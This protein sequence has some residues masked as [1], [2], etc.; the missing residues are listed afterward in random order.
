MNQRRILTIIKILSQSDQAVKSS[1]LCDKLNV[2]SRTLRSD[3]KENKD[4]LRENGIEIQ[5]FPAVGYKL[6][7]FDE[8]KADEFLQGALHD[9]QEHQ[10]IVPVYPEDRI[11]YLIRLFLSSDGY[12]KADDIADR[13]FISRSTLSQRT[14]EIFSAGN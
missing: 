5:S 12:L 10:V 14:T 9:Y 1:V 3:L 8:K 11:H 7:V 13:M 6:V 2:T 4:K